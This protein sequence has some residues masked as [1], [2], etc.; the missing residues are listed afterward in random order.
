MNL[1][2]DLWSVAKLFWPGDLVQ[3]LFAFVMVGLSGWSI[4]AVKKYG[5]EKEWE[6]NWTNSAANID[7]DID[8]EQGSVVELCS[9]VATKHERFAEYLPG[10][11]LTLGLLGTFIGLATSINEAANIM[12]KGSD[13][14]ADISVV[15][16]HLSST[17]SDMKA[18]M[19]GMGT[20]FKTS[21]WGIVCYLLIKF[22]Y[23]RMGFES[24]RMRWTI[25][26]M[27]N[28]QDRK[29]SK[30]NRLLAKLFCNME[31][32]DNKN[33]IAMMATLE[34]LH[35]AQ[36][37]L[38]N[39]QIGTV[40]MEIEKTSIKSDERFANH[41][42][43]LVL[44]L[45]SSKDQIA[46]SLTDVE[47]EIRQLSQSNVS[48]ADILSTQIGALRNDIGIIST[49]A[50]AQSEKHH[51]E[52]I[53]AMNFNKD[54]MTRSLTEVRS[55]VK[56]LIQ[57]NVSQTDILYKQ[58]GSFRHDLGEI[59]AN[60]DA[61]SEKYHQELL[62][63]LNSNKDQMSHSLEDVRS[64][65]KNLT[66]SN[67]TGLIGVKDMVMEQIKLLNNNISGS[68]TQIR[69]ENKQQSAHQVTAIQSLSESFQSGFLRVE[70]SIKDSKE[71]NSDALGK[72][73]AKLENML[74]TITTIAQNTLEHANILS[75]EIKTFTQ[76]TKDS[77]KA[78]D[79][80]AAKFGNSSIA[81]A[82]SVDKLD[83]KIGAVLEKV[84]SELNGS[85][86][87][88]NA[89]VESVLSSTKAAIT[90]SIEGLRGIMMQVSNDL[91]DKVDGFGGLINNTNEGLIK[92][93][94]GMQSEIGVVLASVDSNLN[95]TVKQMDEG[96]SQNLAK[97]QKSLEN[98]VASIDQS[99]NF[100][101]SQI[102]EQLTNFS[103]GMS[104]ATD[105]ITTT[106]N[107]MQQG[108]N[109][110]LCDMKSDLE[111]TVNL[112]NRNITQSTASLD[113]AVGNM[114]SSVAS[115]QDGIT[116]SLL[117]FDDTMKKVIEE[118][119]GVFSIFEASTNTTL[120]NMEE[121]TGNITSIGNTM[122]LG[123]QAVSSS[124]LVLKKC[125]HDLTGII[126]ENKSIL[127]YLNNIIESLNNHSCNLEI[128]LSDISMNS[129]DD[130]NR[131]DA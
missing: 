90:E 24:R 126:S 55:E 19:D 25:I 115:L 124:N 113:S 81:L 120:V 110:V 57:S 100:M 41:H 1:M 39:T 106:I 129:N 83:N 75:T 109:G 123:L 103:N 5:T 127:D 48:Q 31:D 78:I 76:S 7:D 128:L 112:M 30:A 96:F 4:W 102:Q 45:N 43:E 64:E 14:M 33:S 93:I 74:G 59:T 23:S 95:T 94:G 88:M 36:M 37:E 87:M 63:S 119:R 125:L 52:L 12:S 61:Q 11:L 116:H 60:S 58:I 122:V 16:Q 91:Q 49:N 46:G 6:K 62:A 13:T 121:V 44:C 70:N 84:S 65:V 34:K 67:V 2:L 17:L 18:M 15:S 38:L 21:I 66:Q 20:Q 26:R 77:M 35:H 118:Q 98:A 27:N 22:V 89:G 8:S 28:E 72:L 68:L 99:V 131:L 54:Q 71:S 114:S 9:V 105:G 3:W 79:S 56:H 69:S 42:Q 50:E 101:S 86:E 97:T 29:E 104:Q 80:A 117:K 107:L 108:I 130:Q 92:A 32:N 51:H 47:S 40:R 82:E 53:D 85:I 111:G 10:M 73:Q